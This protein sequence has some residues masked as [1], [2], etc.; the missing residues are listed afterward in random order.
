MGRQRCNLNGLDGKHIREKNTG[1]FKEIKGSPRLEPVS[2][3]DQ[4]APINPPLLLRVV[5]GSNRETCSEVNC[6]LEPN[7]DNVSFAD[8]FSAAYTLYHKAVITKSA[9][10]TLVN[11]HS[12]LYMEIQFLMGCN[13]SAS[14]Y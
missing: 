5:R 2:D 12:L 10:E 3:G 7:K 8:Q 9:V 11:F 14:L 1:R 6:A 13:V 4:M